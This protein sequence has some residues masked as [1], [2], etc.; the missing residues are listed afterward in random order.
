MPVS[1]RT[2]SPNG[3]G[4]KDSVTVPFKL[5]RAADVT[6]AVIHSGSTVRTIRLGKLAA[7]ARSVTWDG[8]LGGG[9]TATSGAYTLRLTADGALGVT[10]ASQALTVDL[11]APRLSA[12]A[13]A[14]VRYRKTARLTFTA[15][16]AFSPRVKVSATVTNAKG[17]VLA[18]ARRAAGSSRAWARPARGGRGRKGPTR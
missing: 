16:D 14:S 8:K 3:D 15:R 1:A 6:A 13:T 2:L 18:D 4:V 12:P 7:G 10:S 9:G 11:A 17:R 5:T